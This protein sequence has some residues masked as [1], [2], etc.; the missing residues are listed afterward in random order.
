VY[1]TI[2]E[3]ASTGEVVRR[4][5][6]VGARERQKGSSAGSEKRG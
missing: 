3:R 2:E 1:E 4:Y 6:K 5:L